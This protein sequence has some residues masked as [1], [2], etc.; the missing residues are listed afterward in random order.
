MKPLDRFTDYRIR[1]G[2]PAV[3][4]F[5]AEAWGRIEESIW[6]PRL[7]WLQRFAYRRR[8]AW[9]QIGHELRRER[10]DAVGH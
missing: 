4:A 8:K 1:N 3:P 9:E 5:F 2:F 10:R 6:S 7:R